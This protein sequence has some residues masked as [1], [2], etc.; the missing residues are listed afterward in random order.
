MV[1][2]GPGALEMQA[3]CHPGSLATAESQGLLEVQ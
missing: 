2:T 1:R 3:E